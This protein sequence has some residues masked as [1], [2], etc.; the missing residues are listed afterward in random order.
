M[1][2]LM[3]EKSAHTALCT[4]FQQGSYQ[5]IVSVFPISNNYLSAMPANDA[6]Y[7]RYRMMNLINSLDHEFAMTLN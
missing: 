2:Y 6:N 3:Y 7:C 5:I 1:L 4:A